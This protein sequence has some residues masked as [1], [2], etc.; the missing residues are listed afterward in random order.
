MRPTIHSTIRAQTHLE[1][2][3]LVLYMA[4]YIR[5]RIYGYAYDHERPMVSDSEYDTLKRQYIKQRDKV[6]HTDLTVCDPPLTEDKMQDIMREVIKG[7]GMKNIDED[8]LE[9]FI[10]EAKKTYA[11]L[12]ELINDANT[13]YYRDNKPIM[14]DEE[15]DQAYNLFKQYETSM[16]NKEILMM[17]PDN[18][19][20]QRVGNSLPENS[21]DY[22]KKKLYMPMLSLENVFSRE[23]LYA[24]FKRAQERFKEMQYSGDTNLKDVYIQLEYKLDGI[25]CEVIHT[26]GKL[27]SMATR[28]DGT[29]GE[30]ITRHSKGT[31]IAQV[32]YDPHFNTPIVQ[33]GELILTKK[34]F[35]RINEFR[36]A[37][38]LVKYKNQRNAIAALMRCKRDVVSLANLSGCVK[39][40]THGC[41]SHDIFNENTGKPVISVMDGIHCSYVDT[42]PKINRET[43]PKFSLMHVKDQMNDIMEYINVLAVSRDVMDIPIDGVVI[44]L[45][46]ANR[47]KILFGRTAKYP[48]YAVAYKFKA[49]NHPTVINDIEYNVGR[50]GV[51]TPTAV[52]EPI[53]IEGVTVSRVTLNNARYIEQA[54]IRIGDTVYVIR[55]GDVIPKVVGIDKSK[56]GTTSVP[57]KYPTHC[58]V[59][60]Q[61][62]RKD[63]ALTFCENPYC[64]AQT[65]HRLKYFFSKGGTNPQNI[66]EKTIEV[67]YN[68]FKYTDPLDYFMIT[69]EELQSIGEFTPRTC[70]MMVQSLKEVTQRCDLAKF[71]T[72]L[73]V[74][75]VG[76]S[77]SKRL[78]QHSESL[79]NLVKLCKEGINV[80]GI[81]TKSRSILKDFF[82]RYGETI[83]EKCDKIGFHPVEP[84]P[85]VQGPLT[86]VRV[87]ISGSFADYSREE[88]NELI[89]AYGGTPC[90]AVAKST[91][92]LLQGEGREGKKT[93]KAKKLKIPVLSLEAFGKL[94][95]IKV[96]K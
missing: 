26:S 65:L 72:A 42:F 68:H 20:T 29:T 34:A 92:C 13:A 87:C 25:S 75:S 62:L 12:T 85:L 49:K 35:E 55:S 63:D 39:F 19:P 8:D 67:V 64:P 69:S 32:V 73:G 71:I 93:K 77:L 51:V 57:V 83:L 94:Y 76:T 89:F 10:E 79:E 59:C 6:M 11:M 96:T 4:L 15:Y 36:D 41:V 50:T 16:V 37:N 54:D 30:D 53:D 24:W 28:G 23:E 74:P 22:I 56:R 3:D 88:L 44:K 14:G 70:D 66:G 18:S 60:Q 33:H 2:P 46:L 61:R 52:L 5:L 40:Y 27:K 7:D 90:N 58:P 17:V 45:I 43:V 95:G 47:T 21:E 1:S 78:S 38:G 84:H 86:G 31:T 80:D 48:K 91:T 9:V 82:T 81:G